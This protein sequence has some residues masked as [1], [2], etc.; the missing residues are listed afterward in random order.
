MLGEE[1]SSSYDIDLNPY[2]E[3]STVHG[4]FKESSAS[5]DQERRQLQCNFEE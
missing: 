2:Q 4:G 1:S 3:S 5:T